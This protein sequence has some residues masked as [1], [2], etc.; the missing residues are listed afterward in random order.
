MNSPAWIARS[1]KI[2]AFAVVLMI[3]GSL[4]GKTRAPSVA[5]RDG[6]ETSQAQASGWRS[7]WS[8]HR[9]ARSCQ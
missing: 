8:C 7:A 4:P 9:L 6:V 2:G 1:R 3:G 5:I